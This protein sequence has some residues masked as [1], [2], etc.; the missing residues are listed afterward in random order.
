M[1]RYSNINDQ[2]INFC[3]RKA[4][5]EGIVMLNTKVVKEKLLEF[6]MR[7]WRLFLLL[8]KI[9]VVLVFLVKWYFYKLKT[10]K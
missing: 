4:R 5:R 8:P 9:A 3:Q 1:A 7:I 6:G 10:Q 2:Y